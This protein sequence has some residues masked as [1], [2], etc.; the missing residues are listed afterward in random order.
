MPLL[1]LCLSG[2]P[3]A[4][5]QSISASYWTDSRDI[6]VGCL[7]AIA[8]FLMAYNGTG[9][10]RRDIEFW[11]SRVA[12]ICAIF[13]ALVP[14]DCT[15]SHC[16]KTADWVIYLFS[17]YHP[18]VHLAA[19]ILLFVCLILLIG[20]FSLRAKYKG[21]LPRARIYFAISLGML[22][23]MPVVFFVGCFTDW[24]Q[25]VFWVEWM[26]LTLFGI[27]WLIAGWYKTEPLK[28]LPD[29]AK[30]LNEFN[31][32]PRNPNFPTDITVEAGEQYLFQ[33]RGCWKDWFVE[34]S[35]HG[36][37]PDW[38]PFAYWNR[39]KWQ[40]LFLLCGNIGKSWN[41]KE[42]TFAIGERYIWTVPSAFSGLD[43]EQRKLYLF[44]NDWETRYDNNYALDAKEGGPLKVTIYL[45]KK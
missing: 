15:L 44:A 41:D 25:P 29:G 23:G 11:L 45:L 36:W 27:G 33:A 38:N 37:G 10:C 22:L 30:Y 2:I 31:V 12:G 43:K 40:P 24:Y 9:A 14:A 28:P 4:N 13:V 17:G 6:F 1:V 5:L 42:R 34:C 8:F 3:V 26:G 21:K 39:I 20:L 18:Y 7:M 16:G 19:A 35:A 32:D